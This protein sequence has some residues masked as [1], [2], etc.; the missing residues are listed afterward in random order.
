MNG[1]A[2][3]RRVKIVRFAVSDGDGGDNVGAAVLPMSGPSKLPQ[4]FPLGESLLWKKHSGLRKL[5]DQICNDMRILMH[6]LSKAMV[7]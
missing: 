7:S 6:R 1:R 4:S 5:C 3:F 2:P